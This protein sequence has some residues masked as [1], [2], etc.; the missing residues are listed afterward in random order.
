M[1]KP[2]LVIAP[3]R[4]WIEINPREL[5]NYRDLFFFLVWRDIL[6]RYKQTLLGAAWA[7]LQPAAT[8]VVFTIFFGRLAKIPSDGVPYPLFSYAGLLIWNFFATSVTQASNSLVASSNLV[9]KIYFPRLIMPT[10][11]VL[12]ALVDLAVACTL[13]LILFPYFH[14]SPSWNILALPLIVLIAAASAVGV[15]TLLAALNV[16]Y[17]DF[18]YVVPFM[19]QFWMFASP[20]VY[21]ASMLSEKWR[22]LYALNPMTG[23]VE[24]FRWALLGGRAC[25]LEI[26]CISAASA[27]VII[28]VGLF[29]FQ[30]T[31]EFFA[32]L[33]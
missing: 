25:P 16:K 17:R 18:R 5:W 24:G 31:E 19:L 20:V 30:R 6:V 11:S 3:R 9:T 27:L 28:L 7:I 23:A 14:Y 13:L 1:D 12:A 8:M 2:F 21:P 15:G 10:A 29:Y 4:R 32:D 26:M 33:I 22:L